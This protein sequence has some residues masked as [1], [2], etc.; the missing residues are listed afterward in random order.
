MATLK[1]SHE[2]PAGFTVANEYNP[3]KTTKGTIIA[4][5][6]RGSTENRAREYFQNYIVTP[7]IAHDHRADY[8]A[9]IR[10]VGCILG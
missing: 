8:R 2:P 5:Y 9:S 7:R 6:L 3:E 1:S 4:T 10:Y